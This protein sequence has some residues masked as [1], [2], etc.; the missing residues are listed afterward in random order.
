[1]EM[2]TKGYGFLSPEDLHSVAPS[3][4][5]FCKLQQGSAT[6]SAGGPC[7]VSSIEPSSAERSSAKPQS[8]LSEMFLLISFRKPT[9]PQ[10]R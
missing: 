9:P 5:L 7:F 3:A 4:A 1:M 2:D 6:D 10:D 8:Q